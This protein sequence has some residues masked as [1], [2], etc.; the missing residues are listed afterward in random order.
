[1][2][3]SR[4][5][6]THGIL[7]LSILKLWTSLSLD[8]RAPQSQTERLKRPKGWQL[9]HESLATALVEELA[10]NVQEAL[11][12]YLSWWWFQIFFIFTPIW[13]RCPFWL[14]FFKRGWNHQLVVCSELLDASCKYLHYGSTVWSSVGKKTHAVQESFHP[15]VA[16]LLGWHALSVVH[17]LPYQKHGTDCL[18]SLQMCWLIKIS[19]GSL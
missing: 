8:G 14:I 7:R 10:S 18:E 3:P 9:P 16:A 17:L 19:L 11:T 5:R 15:L 6:D 1:M 4:N 12:K 2:C 13:G